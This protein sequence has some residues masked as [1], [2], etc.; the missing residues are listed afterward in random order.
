MEGCVTPG[1]NRF[2][3]G[4]LDDALWRLLSASD[5]DD[6]IAFTAEHDRAED[7]LVAS[8]DPRWIA[9]RHALAARRE[10]VDGDREAAA[11]GVSAAREAL[12]RCRPC[13][14]TAL[15]LAYL[16]H[17][18]VTADRVD[19]AMLLAIDAG[20]LAEA[21]VGDGPIRAL[22]QA[23][24]WLSLTLSALDLEELA[25]DQALRGHRVAAELPRL[26]DRWRLLQLCAQQHTELAQTLHRR[27]QAERSRELAGSAVEFATTARAGLGARAQRPGPPRRRPGLG[28]GRLR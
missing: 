12:G 25:V 5:R 14:Q 22:H 15:T 28:D 3:E 10:L 18:E 24:L 19:A 7:A 27:G 8:T 1:P 13:P 21:A 20:L 6:P 4:D 2:T 11:A 17:V 23:H 26:A 9:W 16:A